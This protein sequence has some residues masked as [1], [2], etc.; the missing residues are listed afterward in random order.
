MRVRLPIRSSVKRGNVL[1]VIW[2]ILAERVAIDK[3]TNNISLF[4]VIEEVMVPAQ[5]PRTLPDTTED[6]IIPSIMELVILWARTDFEIPERGLGRIR[7]VAPELTRSLSVDQEVDLSKF[8]RLRSRLR[9]PGLPAGGEGTYLF[10][11]DGRPATGEWAQM[12]ELP[13]RVVFQPEDTG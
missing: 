5:P 2:A 7:V 10:K 1:K 8:L 13:L 3:D 6:S 9:L 11:I 12:F 4:N